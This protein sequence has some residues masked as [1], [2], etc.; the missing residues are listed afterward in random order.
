VRRIEQLR[1]GAQRDAQCLV[2]VGHISKPGLQL[3]RGA[4]QPHLADLGDRRG[5]G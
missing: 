5:I 2:D 1:R 3:I 4:Q